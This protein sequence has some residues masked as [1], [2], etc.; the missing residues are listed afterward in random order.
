MSEEIKEFAPVV[1]ETPVA[2]EE[3]PKFDPN[4][5]YTWASDTSIVISGSE[6]GAILNALRNVTTTPEAQAIF[7]AAEAADRVE[8]V[9]IRNVEAGIIVE[10]PEVPK[11]SL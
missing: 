3:G 10:A 1:E 4:K 5:K 8:Q 2:Q 9:L 7:K 6:F 11:G